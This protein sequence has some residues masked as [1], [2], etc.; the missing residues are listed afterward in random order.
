M[1]A[2]NILAG[3][4]WA[5][6]GGLLAGGTMMAEE[7]ARESA[8]Q[9]GQDGSGLSESEMAGADAA[10]AGGGLMVV[11]GVFLLVLAGLEIAGGV[12]LFKAQ[13]AVFI[14]VVAALEALADVGSMI[15]LGSIIFALLGL[16]TAVFAGV[17][18]YQLR[19]EEQEAAG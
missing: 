11:Y 7:A 6:G 12:F 16:V 9:S 19:G 10:K 14:G 5:T 13:K 15:F 4:G 2:V 18:A 17:C 1:A 8:Q 3:I